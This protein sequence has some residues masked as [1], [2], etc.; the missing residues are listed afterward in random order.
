[1][2]SEGLLR[3]DEADL[4]EALETRKQSELAKME[5][6]VSGGVERNPAAPR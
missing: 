6:D 5:R 2:V 3:S 4:Q 1:M